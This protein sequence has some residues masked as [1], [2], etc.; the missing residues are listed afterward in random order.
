MKEL[1]FTI[2]LYPGNPAP[3]RVGTYDLLDFV[4]SSCSCCSVFPMR[5]YVPEDRREYC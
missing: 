3:Y 1:S 4:V 2:E 5:M